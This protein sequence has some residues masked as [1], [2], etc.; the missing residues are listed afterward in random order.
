MSANGYVL[1]YLLKCEYV[2]L[3]F[4]AQVSYEKAAKMR[5]SPAF[6]V[7]IRVFM[8]LC[9]VH[10]NDMERWAALARLRR[11]ARHSGRGSS[12]SMRRASD[13]ALFH[14][15]SGVEWVDWVKK[16]SAKKSC[17]A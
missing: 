17:G 3:R 15:C 7:V 16:N 14:G 2:A 12:A 9:G 5:I 11:T 13:H 6:D 4:V 8:L 10:S 1:S